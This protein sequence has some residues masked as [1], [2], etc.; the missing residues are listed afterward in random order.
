VI[1]DCIIGDDVV[2]GEG[3]QLSHSFIAHGAVIAPNTAKNSHYLSQKLDL[4]ILL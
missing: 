4:P 2:I 3:A 1:H